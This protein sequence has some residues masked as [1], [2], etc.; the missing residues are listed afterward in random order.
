MLLCVLFAGKLCSAW[1]HSASLHDTACILPKRHRDVGC[2]VT[3]TDLKTSHDTF[4]CQLTCM[5][6]PRYS[7]DHIATRQSAYCLLTGVVIRAA[8]PCRAPEELQ[9]TVAHGW[10][11]ADLGAVRIQGC[12]QGAPT[13]I[14]PCPDLGP[15]AES[16]SGAFSGLEAV[17][18][19]S[20]SVTAG[21]CTA[22][23]APLR[24]TSADGALYLVPQKSRRHWRTLLCPQCCQR[25]LCVGTEA[26]MDQSILPCAAR[27]WQGPLSPR[28]CQLEL[29]SGAEAHTRA[30]YLQRSLCHWQ[31][32]LSPRCCQLELSSGAEAHTRAVYLQRSLCHWQ[33]PLY[34]QCSQLELSS[35][36]EAHTRAVRLL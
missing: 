3:R 25:E 16:T 35:G 12:Q 6:W 8:S 19:P 17:T 28:C 5:G 11:L 22:S 15:A 27:H 24:D 10:C 2:L 14:P 4:R 18:A 20:Y 26:H 33:G 30:V 7:G 13:H 1:R 29:S 32:P 23:S 34:P 9:S 21:S 31:G 36:A